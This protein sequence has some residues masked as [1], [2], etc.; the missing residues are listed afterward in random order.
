VNLILSPNYQCGDSL[1]R[2]NAFRL[3]VSN[4][5][6]SAQNTGPFGEIHWNK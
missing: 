3:V 4:S 5:H 1:A 2:S 6:E